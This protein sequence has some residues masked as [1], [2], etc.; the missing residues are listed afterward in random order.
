MEK[1]L[2]DATTEIFTYQ[3]LL[4]EVVFASM[5]PPDETLDKVFPIY[6]EFVELV[7]SFS[8]F[9]IEEVLSYVNNTLVKY[10]LK[11]FFPVFA[12]LFV[13]A[14]LNKLFQNNNEL[15]LDI[16]NL[17]SSIVKKAA[18]EADSQEFT[19]QNPNEIGFSLDF[20]G[21]LL[22]DNKKLTIIGPVG[23]FC[24][25]LMCKNSKLIQTGQHGKQFGYEKDPSS[26]IINNQ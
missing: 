7:E 23:D 16:E 8:P 22:P 3:G 12:G 9:T 14:L 26:Q 20:L 15:I 5:N 18:L 4:K 6:E 25:A 11:P 10:Y 24:G 1:E 2:I 17:C 21:Y 13:N 19:S